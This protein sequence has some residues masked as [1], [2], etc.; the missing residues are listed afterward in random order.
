MRTL[1]IYSSCLILLS[2]ISFSVPVF[3]QVTMN[4]CGADFN[5]ALNH[6]GGRFNAPLVA[7]DRAFSALKE[8]GSI[9]TWGAS[10]TGGTN[11]PVGQGYEAIVSNNW[12]FA[13]IKEDGSIV[14]WGRNEFGGAGAPTDSGYT[15]IVSSAKA[16]AALKEDGSISVWGDSNSG[17]ANAPFDKGYVSIVSGGSSFAALKADGSITS[18]GTQ[19][20]APS[21]NGY[22]FIASNINAF[23]A[24]KADGTVSSWGNSL[25]GGSNAPTRTGFYEII[26]SYNGFSALNIDGRITSWGSFGGTEPAGSNFKSIVANN[27]AYAA[28]TEDGSIATWGHASYGGNGGPTDSGYTSIIASTRSFVAMKADGSLSAWGGS[29]N[30]GD[31]LPTDSGFLSVVAAD[32]AFAGLKADGSIVSWGGTGSQNAPID[33]GYTIIS[34]NKEAFAAMKADGT[35]VSWGHSLSG[36]IDAPTEAG[37]VSIN[38]VSQDSK[39]DCSLRLDLVAPVITLNGEQTTN[40]I[41]GETYEELGATAIDNKDGAIE[42]TVTG[43]IDDTSIEA[44]HTI[45]Y[46]A[47][48]SAGNTATKIRTVNVLSEDTLPPVITLNGDATITISQNTPYEELGATAADERDGDLD[49]VILSDVDI[50]T[51]GNYNVRYTATDAAG[52]KVSVVRIVHVVDSTKPVITLNGNAAISIA[53]GETYTDK[54][55]T[56]SDNVDEELTVTMTGSVDTQ[57]VA[58]YTLTYNVMDSAGNSA[59]PVTRVVTVTDATKPVITLNGNQN[60]TINMG[61]T[62][63]DAGATVTDNVDTNLE[64]TLTGNVD[65]NT[66][67]IY[68]LTYT[69]TDTAGNSAS[70][71]R[72]VTVKDSAKPVI[73]LNGSRILKLLVGDTYTE[74]GATATDDVDTDLKIIISG[75]VDTTTVGSYFVRYSTTDSTGNSAS[76]TRT[77]RVSLPADVTKPV[78]TLTGD[79]VV[80]LTI[81]DTYTEAGATAIDDRDGELE[82][83]ITGEVDTTKAGQSKI[84]YTA[85]DAAGNETKVFRGVIVYEPAKRPSSGG[86]S[87]NWFMLLL[88]GFAGFRKKLFTGSK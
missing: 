67:G 31:N 1:K 63:T 46:K 34:S 43:S 73:K 68:T 78:I 38:G 57:V 66:A 64:A 54:G 3:A 75:A 9:V 62:Y 42:V 51:V 32:S 47:T 33:N 17:G 35:I 8:D 79:Q 24:L 70:K 60:I 14:A 6:F 40:I 69:A 23:A 12:A 29:N 22:K 71:T 20:N 55:A 13:A 44:T 4:E 16:F 39:T 10:S 81:G 59:L 26:S 65:I 86:G 28:L 80:K 36:G 2:S 11:A 37:F 48:D 58:E 77:V 18:W 76:I 50:T 7:N 52:N 56:A 82:V 88:A 5:S 27:S 84:Y 83:I 45:T 49:V 85:T 87:M 21:D 74:M 41:I 19:R 72:T 53:Q 61:D 25:A 15:T 30:E